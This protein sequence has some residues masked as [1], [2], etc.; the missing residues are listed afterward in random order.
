M[1]IILAKTA[2]FC[3]GVK[4][5]MDIALKSSE[6]KGARI[7][8][9]GPL[10]HNQQAVDMLREK[11]IEPLEEGK[12]AEPTYLVI[13]AHGVSPKTAEELVARGFEIVDATCPH[14]KRSQERIRDYSEKGYQVVIVG[15]RDHAEVSGLKG[16]CAGPC[17]V[18]SS[19]EEAEKLQLGERV[20]VIAQ[21]TFVEGA[22][23][24]IID[25]IRKR[26]KDVASFQ[27]ICRA[28]QERQDEVL[29]LAR[30]CD[31][32]IVVGGKH[33]ANTS[34]LAQLA[35]EKGVSAFHVETADELNIDEIRRFQTI[36]VTAGA[37]TPSWI[38][39]AVIERLES[40]SREVGRHL[41]RRALDAVV[42]SNLYSSI[43]AIALAFACCFIQG[44]TF[45]FRFLV[46]AFCYI[47]ATSILNR[48]FEESED[49]LHIPSR[50][51][52]YRRHAAKLVA[53][54]IV[55]IVVSLAIS[56]TLKW[57]L[58]LFLLIAYGLGVMYSVRIV[59]LNVG[60]M[61]IRRLKDI[62]GSKDIFSALGWTAIVVFVPFL[63]A[64]DFGEGY[65]A[66][67]LL[68]G[69]AAFIVVMIK[70]ILVDL[71]DIYSDRRMGRE[72]LPVFLGEG[73]ANALLLALAAMLAALFLFAPGKKLFVG[74]GHANAAYALLLSPAYILLTIVLIRG[75]ILK[76]ETM[77]ILAADG[78]LLLMG[79][80]CAVFGALARV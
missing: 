21:T 26:A 19:P 80:T 14:V 5:A 63:Y 67:A 65:D 62:P 46:I 12:P 53:I 6:K 59:P 77:S 48:I 79:L 29:Q 38:T 75:K 32:V 2:G 37:S 9:L 35:R 72:T 56:V 74:A 8:T 73:K 36:G 15:D 27:S 10:I 70:S 51:R 18:V 17:E 69:L 11:N 54:S 50:V 20:A 7:Y 1:K 39:Q 3:M 58:A 44:I 66:T 16:F 13:R 42:A 55:L 25:V 52:F 60:R 45:N 34:R 49:K 76:S 41:L 71:A 68:T 57:E 30:S 43:A 47:Y 22:Y 28:T 24:K 40:V 78:N 23:Q 61:R 31:A 33:S 64:R 4:R